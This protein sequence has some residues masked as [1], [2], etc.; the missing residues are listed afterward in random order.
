[1]TENH[2]NRLVAVELRKLERPK[3]AEMG[4]LHNK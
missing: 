2:I 3:S 1:L 4:V